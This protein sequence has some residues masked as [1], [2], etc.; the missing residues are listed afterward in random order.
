MK[1][2]QTSICY[3]TAILASF[4]IVSC[5]NNLDGKDENSKEL[6]NYSSIYRIKNTPI[7]SIATNWSIN[8]NTNHNSSEL[9]T[10]CEF[11][12]SSNEFRIVDLIKDRVIKTIKF[13]DHINK[14]GSVSIIDSNQFAFLADEA[15]Y[16]YKND[17][18]QR[19][20]YKSFEDGYIPLSYINILYRPEQNKIISGALTYT[21]RKENE[22][23]YS[24]YFLNVYDLKTMKSSRIPFSYPKQFHG[25]KLGIPNLYLS[26]SDNFLIVSFKLDDNIYKINLLTNNIDTIP[27][28]SNISDINNFF[29]PL[30]GD[31]KSKLDAINKN[32]LHVGGYGMAFFNK[33]TNRIYRLY[34][35]SLPMKDKAGN[36]FNSTD[37]GTHILELDITSGKMKEIQLSNAQYYVPTHWS[38]NRHNNTLTYP[39]LDDHATKKDL[40]FYNIHNI[41]IYDL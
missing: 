36:Y 41:S 27:C 31:R 1:V 30:E 9:S 35:P 13:S 19:I 39:K 12:Y 16:V 26:E 14:F 37:K 5:Q 18:L 22:K 25:F 17:S 34:Q 21:K 28:K 11:N 29:Y 8:L 33:E 6:E 2:I 20:N 32:D 3:L 4:V 15:F 38:Y 10:F 24:S 40:C 7:T 23:S